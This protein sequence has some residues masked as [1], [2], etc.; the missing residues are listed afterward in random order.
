[1]RVMLSVIKGSLVFLGYV[2]N[3]LFWSFPLLCLSVLKL[4]PI[5]KFRST[6][7]YALDNLASC[8]ISC[9]RFMDRAFNPLKITVT[10]EQN[11]STKDWY[12]VIANHQSWVDILV[13][14][15]IFNRKIPFLKF[16]LKKELIYVPILGLTWWALDFP[17]MRRYSTAQLR[18][19]PRLKGKD[20]EITRAACSK[21]KHKPVSIMN[22]VEGTR[23]KADKHK[24]QNSPFTHLLRPKAGGMAFALSAMGAHI[25]KLID[26]AIYYPDGIPS[27]WDYVSGKV[28]EVRV[29]IQLRDIDENLRGDYVNDKVFKK[30]FQQELNILWQ[31][32]DGVLNQLAEQ[33]YKDKEGSH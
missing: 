11:L 13:L 24:K 5:K 25:N 23:F 4:I 22:F 21:F 19:N 1:M 33:P 8:W 29:N 17:F 20:I 26:V 12:M 14:Q 27:F 32:K 2:I 3:T 31:N 9:N 15:Q 10:G 7:T 30:N 16:F 28:K 6:C 18:K